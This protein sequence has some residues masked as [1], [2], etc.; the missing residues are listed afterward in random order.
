MADIPL[1]PPIEWFSPPSDI[2]TDK[3]FVIEPDGKVFGYVA[4]WNTCHAGLSG[5]TRPPKGSPTSYEYAHQGETLT[6]GGEIIRTAVIAGGTGHAPIEQNSLL[7]PEFYENTGTQ[8]MRVRYGEDDNG[9]WFAGALW[10]DVND[11]DVA[12][13]RAS[14]V[15]G[16]WRWHAAWRH[17]ASGGYDFAGACL[18]NIPGYPMPT[19]GGHVGG[20]AGQMKAIAASL[21]EGWIVTDGDEWVETESGDND[22][23]D[24]TCAS[25]TSENLVIS[26]AGDS[27]DEIVAAITQMMD[28]RK[29][30]KAIYADGSTEVVTPEPKPEPNAEILEFVAK[31]SA[32]LDALEADNIARQLIET[33]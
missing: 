30:K 6:A 24:G 4:L 19:A 14:S 9:L 7:V 16:D 28:R 3:R 25:A 13:I 31:V 2:P 5:C 10:P 17:T 18:V 32:R 27:D 8:L 15:S 1:N 23:C 12:R 26:F 20:R 21:G 22:M 11:L 29:R 33:T